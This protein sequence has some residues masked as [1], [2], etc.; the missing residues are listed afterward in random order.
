SQSRNKVDYLAITKRGYF[1]K[2]IKASHEATRSF[3]G[4]RSTSTIP[5]RLISLLAC[6]ALVGGVA[7]VRA[8]DRDDERDAREHAHHGR[9]AYE[10]GLGGPENQNELSRPT[11]DLT[12]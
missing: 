6:A 4:E 3:R 9:D 10:L 7:Y 1:V 8:D 11:N 2:Q 5:V 12:L